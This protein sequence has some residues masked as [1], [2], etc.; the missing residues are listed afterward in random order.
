MCLVTSSIPLRLFVPK[1]VAVHSR[2][3][4]VKQQEK[5]DLKRNK[6][7]IG[8][9]EK[10]KISYR[11]ELRLCHC[12]FVCL[13]SSKIETFF[14]FQ[15]HQATMCRKNGWFGCSIRTREKMGISASE[16]DGNHLS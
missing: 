8:A 12:L 6:A 3:N 13:L 5:A 9:R 2:Y 16:I 4:V 10:D 7:N 1:I 14:L 11:T 15:D